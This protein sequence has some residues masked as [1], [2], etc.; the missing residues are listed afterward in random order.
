MNPFDGRKGKRL[1]YSIVSDIRFF[2]FYIGNETILASRNCHNINVVFE[3]SDALGNMYAIKLFKTYDE[4]G[5]SPNTSEEIPSDKNSTD[6]IVEYV[7]ELKEKNKCE[8]LLLPFNKFRSRNKENWRN[9]IVRFFND[10]GLR[11]LKEKPLMEFNDD[12]ADGV[13]NEGSPLEQLTAIFCNVLRFDEKYDVINEEWTRYRAS[14]YI[15]YYNDDSYQITPPLKEW[16]TILW[17]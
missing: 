3:T 9:V 15:R 16:E 12:Y 8:D 7:Q 4:V 2:A 5:N 11:D 6:L 17:L 1:P 10:F 14:Q 13:I